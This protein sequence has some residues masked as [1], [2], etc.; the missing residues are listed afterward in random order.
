MTEQEKLERAKLYIDKLAEGINPLDDTR[1]S[2]NDIVNNVRL[3]RCF[4]FISDILRQVIENGIEQ[5]K[6]SKYI[7]NAFYL[8]DEAKAL[9]TPQSAPLSVKYITDK[10]NSLIDEETSSKLKATTIA[11]FLVEA[12]ML[13]I[14]ER[15]DG[16]NA[17]VPTADGEAIGLFLQER[18]GQYGSYSVVCYN[19]SA[20]QFIYDNIDAIIEYNNLKKP[21]KEKK[22]E[23][24]DIV[25]SPG[26]DAFVLDLVNN[27]VPVYEIAERLHC[28]RGAV[29]RRISKLLLRND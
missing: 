24:Q 12:G 22:E 28:S 2:E 15:P 13:E 29:E 9:L 18:Q 27:N 21:K 20:Q 11:S 26:L 25:W 8:S 17:K 7:K 10:I 19:E 16:K 23:P 6:K 4:F 3:S 5:P 14:I 1:L